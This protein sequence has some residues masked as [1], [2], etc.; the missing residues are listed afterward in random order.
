MF[1]QIRQAADGT[2]RNNVCSWMRYI[3][4]GPSVVNMASVPVFTYHSA[5]VYLHPL[6]HLL[7]SH[8]IDKK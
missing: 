3:L 4:Y 1:E 6:S 5:V 2:V 8:L 7:L